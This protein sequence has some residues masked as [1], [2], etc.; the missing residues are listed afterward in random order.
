MAFA[1][2]IEFDPSGERSTS[3]Y[4]AVT[5]RVGVEEEPPDGL[6]LHSAGYTDD[7]TFRIYDVWETEEQADRF[8]SER[9]APA[10][11]AAA[12][13]DSAEPV[14]QETYRLHNVIT[15]S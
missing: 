3:N 12:D 7:G 9:F 1:R 5:K 14:K 2:L 10:L 11:E 8:F 4:D 6:I 13:P 15:S